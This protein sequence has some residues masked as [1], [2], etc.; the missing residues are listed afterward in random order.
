MEE[1]KHGEEKV[2]KGHSGAERG[3]LTHITMWVEEEWMGGW[4][5]ETQK[6]E[7]R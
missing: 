5:N 7:A 6:F 2:V 3:G 1:Q 4:L